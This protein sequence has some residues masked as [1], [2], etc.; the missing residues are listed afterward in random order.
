MQQRR[1]AREFALQVLYGMDLQD[2]SVSEVLDFFWSILENHEDLRKHL[3]RDEG[4]KQFALQL[5]RGTWE[6]VEEI[7]GIIRNYSEHWSV[8]R[9]SRVDRSIL[10][11]AVYE[12]LFCAD[13]PPKV[14]L[15]E[16]IDLGKIYGSENSGAFINGLLDALYLDKVTKNT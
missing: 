6:S 13:I 8:E 1:R 2:R 12:I 3:P 11:M 7:D 14:S 15:N 10:R 16:A 4:A 9:M 5:V